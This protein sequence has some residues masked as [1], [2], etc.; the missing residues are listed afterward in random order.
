M[1]EAMVHLASNSER[2][3]IEIAIAMCSTSNI[4]EL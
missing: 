3:K 4:G 2:E 1:K